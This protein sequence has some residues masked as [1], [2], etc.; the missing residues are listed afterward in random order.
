MATLDLNSQG[1][2]RDINDN[3]LRLTKDTVDDSAAVKIVTLVTLVYLPA[4]FVA[5]GA[6]SPSCVGGRSSD[7]TNIAT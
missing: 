1:T 7:L 6:K 3:M 2:A 5:V 4:S